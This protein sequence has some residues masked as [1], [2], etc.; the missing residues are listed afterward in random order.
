MGDETNKPTRQQI[1][2]QQR[3]FQKELKADF[4][5]FLFYIFTKHLNYDAPSLFQYRIADYLQTYERQIILEG[6]RGLGKSDITACF[7]IWHLWKNPQLKIMV[8]S[9]AKGRATDFSSFVQG[10]I[11]DVPILQHLGPTEEYH[12]RSMEKF[13]VGPATN[14][15]SPSVKS[16]GV[17]GQI[18]GSRADI[19]IADDIET[20]QNA[21]TVESRQK[22]ADAVA[23]FASVLTSKD[24]SRTI[25][26]G[27]PHSE[28][29]LYNILS[30]RNYKTRIFPARYPADIEKYNEKLD[31]YIVEQLESG[32]AVV[33][34]ATDPDRFDEF[35]LLNK[36]GE[37]GKTKFT[38]QFM[39]DS[40]L[41]DENRYPLKLKDLIVTSLSKQKGPGDVVYASGKENRRSDIH[42]PGFS[43]DFWTS[44]MFADTEWIPYQQIVMALDPSGRGTDE[45]GYAIVA[46]LNGKLF[47]LASGGI[48]GGYEDTSLFSIA[49]LAKEYGVHDITVESNFGDGVFNKLLEPVL[50]RVH[51]CSLHEVRSTQQKELRIIDSLEPVMNGHRLVFDEAVVRKD[52]EYME[53]GDNKMEYSLF[54]QMTRLTKERGCLKHDDRLDAL[55]MAVAFFRESMAVDSQLALQQYQKEKKQLAIDEMIDGILNKDNSHNDNWINER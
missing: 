18:T 51:P 43:S 11:R 2:K 55:E 9:A 6:Y 53:N 38:M 13:D 26:L 42:N 24:E 31:P 23:E 30:Q 21:Q 20:S 35:V 5:K 52:L 39:L 7:V 14:S 36:E 46:Y 34:Q 3:E 1:R 22:I 40:S 37:V 49:K 29:T 4:R 17:F 48:K 15:Q 41:S 44:P 47:V 10:L 8:V 54:Y 50:A 16:V 33:G 19:I 32:K 27:T 12:R 45:T 25:F 28:E